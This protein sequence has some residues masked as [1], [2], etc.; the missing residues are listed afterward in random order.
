[1]KY[2]IA[3][4]VGLLV[5]AAIIAAFLFCA[6]IL[7]YVIALFTDVIDCGPFCGAAN[8]I[9]AGILPLLLLMMAGIGLLSLFT[10]GAAFLG[11]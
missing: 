2:I 7:G 8:Y 9:E 11:R 3:P 5:L 1:M 10:I 4:F 6:G